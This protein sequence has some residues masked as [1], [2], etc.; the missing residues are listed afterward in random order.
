MAVFITVIHIRAAVIV[1]IFT[2]AYHSILEAATPNIAAL[3][4]VLAVV[5]I[6]IAALLVVSAHWL[7]S[8]AI[9]MRYT[10][11]VT[12]TKSVPVGLALLVWKVRISV[13]V[14]IV[15]V[16]AAVIV[17]IF[18]RALDTVAKALSLNVA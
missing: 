7:L 18:A 4:H 3:S 11:F 8:A 9:Q 14:A 15:H 13:L 16:R 10:Y 1:E 5:A 2:C 12:A 6:R 17:G